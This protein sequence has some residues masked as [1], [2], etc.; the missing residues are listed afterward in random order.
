MMYIIAVLKILVEFF[1]RIGV[2]VELFHRGSIK[3]QFVDGK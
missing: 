1:S 2:E 3:L